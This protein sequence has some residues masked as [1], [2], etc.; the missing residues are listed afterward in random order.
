MSETINN[1]IMYYDHKLKNKEDK[2]IGKL[3][4]YDA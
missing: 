3:R 4:F 2:E 1:L